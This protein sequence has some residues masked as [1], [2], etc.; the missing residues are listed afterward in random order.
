MNRAYRLVWNE[1][2]R[3]YVPVA[4]TARARGKRSGGARRLAPLAVVIGFALASPAYALPTG[5]QLAAG[6][7]SFARPNGTSLVVTQ[8]SDQA[9]VNWQSFGIG[10]GESTRFIQPSASSVILNRIL[11][12][13]ASRI[14]GSLQSNGIVYMTNPNGVLFARGAQ[15]EKMDPAQFRAYIEAEMAKWGQVVKQAGIKAQ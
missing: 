5:E 7:V 13:E 2:L 12:G 15:V 1:A 6:N 14:Y 10:A 8:G 4:E 3:T 9:I 11:G